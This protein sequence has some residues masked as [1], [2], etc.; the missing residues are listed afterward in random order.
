MKK[1]SSNFLAR[2]KSCR[3]NKSIFY[4]VLPPM[5]LAIKSLSR[6]ESAPLTLS[7]EVVVLWLVGL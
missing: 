2:S 5:E 7:I 4:R 6:N 3:V 1:P